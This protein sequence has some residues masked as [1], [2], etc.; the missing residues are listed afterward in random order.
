MAS[1]NQHGSETDLDVVMMADGSDARASMRKQNR[2]LNVASSEPWTP[3][4]AN[5]PV[6]A[7]IIIGDSDDDGM[8][9]EQEPMIGQEV[10]HFAEIFSPP[11]VAVACRQLGLRAD[12]SFDLDFGCD[13]RLFE[14][15]T[16]VSQTLFHD[17]L[18]KFIMLSPPCTMYSALQVCF[19]N[20]EKLSE[21]ELSLR[22]EEAHCYVDF[23]MLQARRQMQRKLWWCF[24]HPQRASSWDR[25]SV[26]AVAAMA[27]VEKVTFHQCAVGL[28]A[29]GSNIPIKKPTT[30]M[31]NCP[32]VISAFRPMVCRCQERHQ[33]IEGSFNGIPLSKFCQIYPDGLCKLLAKAVAEAVA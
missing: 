20:F 32:A 23:S 8:D 30:F 27:G 29:P 4:K 26:K 10:Q 31:T 15:R 17:N 1:S 7:E 33:P 3:Y 2:K 18:V 16:A 9:S 12:F 25:E 21:E 22:W 13:L 14:C 28:K 24:E 19:R 6:R 5:L 11:R